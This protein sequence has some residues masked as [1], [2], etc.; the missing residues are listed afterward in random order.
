MDILLLYDS[1]LL[2]YIR[3]RSVVEPSTDSSSTES[4]LVIQIYKTIEKYGE[5]KCE[6]R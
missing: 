6:T 4:L 3:V 1:T 5:N 2:L